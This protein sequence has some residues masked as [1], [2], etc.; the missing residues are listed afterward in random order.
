M[1][2]PIV[3]IIGRPNVWKSRLFNR[4]S[5][6]KLAIVSDIAWT[7]RDRI[8]S[9]VEDEDHVPYLLVDTGW[10][11]F[12]ASQVIEKSTQD[13]ARVAIDDAD[14]ILFVIDSITWII[15]EDYEIAEYLRKNSKNS[16]I[17]LLMSKCDSAKD[18]EEWDFYKLGFW[19][20]IKVS[21]IHKKWIKDLNQKIETGLK[22]IWY[23]KENIRLE[24]D[25]DKVRVSVLWRPNTWKSSLVN[26][27]LKEEKLIVSDIPW[28]TRDST[29]TEV[30]YE[31]KSYTLID[32]AWIRRSWKIEKWIEKYSLLRTIRSLERSDVTCLLIEP[33]EELTSQDQ[34][35]ISLI[36]EKK[37]WLILIVNKWD[38][39]DKWEDVKSLFI[40]S[41]RKKLPFIPWAPVLFMSAKTK[42]WIVKIFPLIDMIIEERKK[43]ITTWKL[44]AFIAKIIREHVPSWTKHV[45]P[46][47]FYMTQIWISPPSF[48]IF[49]NKKEYFHFSYLRYIENKIREI[50]WFWWTWIEI[51]FVDRKS[52]YAK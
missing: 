26:S 8:Y 40:D 17:I 25:E 48:K 45:K 32:T 7:T 44:N 47:I 23:K 43:K 19:K 51:E 38:L 30:I 52:I 10:L 34:K 22:E 27:F 14:I 5:S 21:S 1:S 50:F 29:D 37:N 24:N 6:D 16:K 18:L 31:W 33:G 15:P 4:L 9:K 49:V 39:K 13:Q 2:F 46:K 11:D 42:K 3:A 35:I 41:L 12:K 36:L 28:T 20:P